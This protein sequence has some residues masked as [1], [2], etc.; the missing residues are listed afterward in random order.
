MVSRIVQT[1]PTVTQ[2]DQRVVRMVQEVMQ[3]APVVEPVV[4]GTFQAISMESSIGAEVY[5]LQP[6][7]TEN[8]MVAQAV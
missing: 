5:D 6:M 4:Q 1:M 7:A 8:K 3:E 2:M